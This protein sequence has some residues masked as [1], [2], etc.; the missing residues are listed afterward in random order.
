MDDT[1]VTPEPSSGNTGGKKYNE[2]DYFFEKIRKINFQSL[3]KPLAFLKG[4]LPGKANV[5]EQKKPDSG[6]SHS[7]EKS[8]STFL[9]KITFKAIIIWGAA[10]ALCYFIVQGMFIAPAAREK[11]KKEA[12]KKQAAEQQKQELL[13]VKTFKVSR[14]NYE[15]SLNALGNIKGGVEFKLSFEIPGVINSINYREGE[16]YEEGALLVSLK[17]DDI[18][19]RLKKAQAEKNK[20][21]T[22]LSI[23]QGKYEEHQKLY[24][25]G[26]IPQTTLDKVKLEVDSAQYEVEASDL[27]VKMNEAMLEKSNLY[28]PSDGMIGELY[29]EEG[30]A[31]TPNTLIGSH[32][33]TDVVSAEFGVVEKDVAKLALGQKA[34]VYVD[35]YADKTFE[36]VVEN[37]SPVVTGSSRTATVRVRLE[38]SEGLLLPGMFARIK[39]LLYSKRNALIV[40]T[41]SVQ[42]KEDEASVF[43]VDPRTNK[44]A[45]RNIKIGY[46]RP[47]Y[48]QV[49]AGLEEGE[50]VCVSGLEKLQDGVEVKVVEQQEASV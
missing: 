15:D 26:S 21:E 7:V 39:I 28:A 27:E 2:F 45:K 42:G 20:S 33:S 47:D 30:E 31:L 22:A 36:G 6:V 3:L 40:P 19:I 13:P 16:R 9:S 14:F 29:V 10:I 12:E 5:P 34:R 38:N 17:Q 44:V 43:V 4:F 23:A 8:K 24:K 25:I 37:I 46:T 11:E 41:D 32:I 1:P 50:L 35:A 49:D 48:S 18:L